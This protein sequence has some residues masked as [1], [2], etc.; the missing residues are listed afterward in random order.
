MLKAGAAWYLREAF[1]PQA[2]VIKNPSEKLY[3]VCLRDTS[4]TRS[5]ADF[6][7]RESGSAA[8]GRWRRLP[9]L[10]AFPVSDP[11]KTGLFVSAKWACASHS[12][13]HC[14]QQLGCCR[15]PTRVPSKGGARHLR[16]AARSRDAMHAAPSL[17]ACLQPHFPYTRHFVLRPI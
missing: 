7:Q 9:G 13:P 12:V 4:R 11:D 1:E 15:L 3:R 8:G 6:I 10:S 5:N 14:L 17:A 16:R 2:D